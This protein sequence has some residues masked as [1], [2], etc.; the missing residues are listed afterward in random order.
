M[1]ILK[2]RTGKETIS[3]SVGSPLDSH[4]ECRRLAGAGFM[5]FVKQI[6]VAPQRKFKRHNVNVGHTF[7]KMLPTTN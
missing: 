3:Y 7:G 2:S 6:F 4:S 5:P 1:K